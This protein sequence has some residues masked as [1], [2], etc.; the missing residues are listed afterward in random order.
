MLAQQCLDA[1]KVF[2]SEVL[3]AA[4]ARAA[5]GGAFNR[6]AGSIAAIAAR[7]VALELAANGAAMA[8]ELPGD[9]RRG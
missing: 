3:V 7:T 8:A 6:L 9:L 4:R 2:G 5:S 1:M